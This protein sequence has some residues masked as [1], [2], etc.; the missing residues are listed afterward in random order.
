MDKVYSLKDAVAKFVE[1]GDTICFGGF[2]TNRKPYAA[3]GEILR[4]GQKDF[5]VWAGP[6]GGDWD[7]MIGE[8]RV[9]NYINCYTANSGYTNVSRRFRAAIEKGELTYEDYSQDVLMLQLHAASLGLPYLP[10]RLMQ[11]SG[12]MKFWGISEEKRAADPKL[13]NL[14]CVEV[15]NPFQPGQKV[16]AVPVPKLDTA[17]IHVQKASPDG[18][19]IIEGDEFHDVDIA[20]A[21]RK[22][23]VTCDELVS[24]E[25][26]RRDPTLTRIF[27]ECVSAVV[28]APYGAWP[29]QCYNYYDNDP[30]ALREYDKASKYLDAEDA[31][32]QLA[33]AAAKAAKAA[34]KAP[35]DA[36]LA[37][38]AAKAAK[39]AEDAANGTAIPE[40]FKDYLDK[41]VYSVTDH[42]DLLNKIGGARLLSLRNAPHLGYSNT[43]LK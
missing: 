29:S 28:H 36:K 43:H 11:G 42:N 16:V 18:T 39:A 6:A 21:A 22:V 19:C 2:T 24:N 5:T 14:K 25:F 3:V 33:K 38:A 8:G 34:E 41:W 13:D 31:K 9:K 17:I 7:M 4:Q 1:S 12:L 32:V 37:E 40:T 23:I 26:I 15:E 20:V 10:V 35:E 27:G 30:N